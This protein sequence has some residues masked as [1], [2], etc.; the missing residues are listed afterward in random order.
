M[1][2][3]VVKVRCPACN[4][5]GKI[6]MRSLL[7]GDPRPMRGA[8]GKYQGEEMTVH[9]PASV[10]PFACGLEFVKCPQGENKP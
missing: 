10:K 2:S 4:F 9:C 8:S 6:S 1:T 5:K 7:A 3:S